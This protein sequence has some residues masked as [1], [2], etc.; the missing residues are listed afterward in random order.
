MFLV[1]VDESGDSGLTSQNRYFCLSALVVHELRWKDVLDQLIA[2]RQI[3]RTTYG[4]KLREE[5]HSGAFIHRPKELARIP[6]HVRLQIMKRVL[7][8]EALIPDINVVNIVVDKRGKVATYDV[9][10]NAWQ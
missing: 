6:K 4:L 5:I 9:F 8:Y 1:Y 2:V 3:L 7:E 10:E